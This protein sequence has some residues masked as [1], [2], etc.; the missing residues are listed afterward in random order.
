MRR[1]LVTVLVF[2]LVFTA[3]GQDKDVFL[4]E[5]FNDIEKWEPLLF[6]KIPKHST[7]KITADGTNSILETKSDAS[8]S[9]LI[10]KNTFNVNDFPKVKWRWKTSNTFRAGNAKSKKGDDYPIRIYIIFEY[11]PS[12]AGFGLRAKY[13]LA[14]TIYGEYPPHT[15]LNYIWANREHKERIIVSPYTKRSVMIKLQSGNDSTGIWIDEEI[16]IL[17]DYEEA[18]GK[19]PPKT[20]SIAI[21]ND[22]DNTGESATSYI[23]YIK[24][25][26]SRENK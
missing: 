21:M 26:K 25:F 14:K 5:T 2:F 8:A 15:S 18:F 20:A 23:D 22:S 10:Y 16:D 9:G 4:M 17:K 3:L 12:E 7:Y 19:T 6:P 24:I 1:F 13:S 11:N